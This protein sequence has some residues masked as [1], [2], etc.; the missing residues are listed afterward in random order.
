[1][2][3]R[4]W[5][6][7]CLLGLAVT[8]LGCGERG[9]AN[10]VSVTGTVLYDGEPVEG[11]SVVF[12]SDSSVASGMTD[13]SGRFELRTQ[14]QGS[15]AEPGDY[16]V[17]VTKIPVVD[18][19]MQEMEAAEEDPAGGDAQKNE[20]PDRYANF[21]DSPLEFTVTPGEKNDFTIELE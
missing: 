18:A 1:M 20:L 9:D 4:S 12:R 8:A 21:V 10:L 6:S 11:A 19:V 17:M 16:K 3:Y 5:V 14:G 2:V 13:S 15:G 7:Y